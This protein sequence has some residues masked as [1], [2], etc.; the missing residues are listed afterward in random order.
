MYGMGV[1][2]QDITGGITS[3]ALSQVER[4]S[5][6]SELTPTYSY[7]PN[8]PSVPPGEPGAS[9]WGPV[10]KPSVT[11]YGRGGTILARYAPYGVPAPERWVWV[12]YA[13]AGVGVIATGYVLYKAF[14]K[15]KQAVKTNPG[16]RKRGCVTRLRARRARRAA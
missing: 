9:W 5:I 14:A 10:A 12:G 4:I 2:F 1:S 6:E 16:R 7:N 3:A 13:A 8:Q 15:P 11:V